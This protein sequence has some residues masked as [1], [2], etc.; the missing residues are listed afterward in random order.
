M[1]LALVARMVCRAALHLRLVP[2]HL[3]FTTKVNFD[4]AIPNIDAEFTADATCIRSV[5][6]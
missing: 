3:I 2:A 4:T 6:A 5:V 1:I